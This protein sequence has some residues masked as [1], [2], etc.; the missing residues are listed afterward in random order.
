LDP[1]PDPLIRGT[2]PGIRIRTQMSG[3]PNTGGRSLFAHDDTVTGLRFVPN[4]HM[5]FTCGKDGQLKQ[6]DAD[7]FQRIVTLSGRSQHETVII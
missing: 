2:D 6:W 3:I 5:V 1:D 7:I 4:T